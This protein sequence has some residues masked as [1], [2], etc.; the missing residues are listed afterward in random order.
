MVAII[1]WR[2]TWPCIASKR[3]F[4]RL[5]A[6]RILEHDFDQVPSCMRAVNRSIETL[7][8]QVWDI[9]A[10]IYVGVAQKNRVNAGGIER[11]LRI[12]CSCFVSRTAMESAIQQESVGAYFEKMH[13]AGNGLCCTKKS[14]GWLI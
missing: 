13:R 14:Y 10:V 6:R 7:T 8:N 1:Q 2:A 9:P 5:D 12:E 3:A 4:S 11:K